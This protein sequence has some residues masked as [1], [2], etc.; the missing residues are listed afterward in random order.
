MIRTVV[1]ELARGC[2]YQKPGGT[3]LVSDGPGLFCNRLPF[4]LTVCPCCNAGIKPSRGWTWV[5][6]KILL[7]SSKEWMASEHCN[8][9]MKF[10]GALCLLLQP[11]E[12]VGLI[13]IGESFYKTPDS[14]IKEANIQGISRRISAIPRGFE[15]GKTQIW[16]AHRK[17][18]D[19]ECTKCAGGIIT[20]QNDELFCNECHGTGWIKTPGVFSAFVPQRIEYIVTGKETQEELERKEKTGITLVKLE[21]TK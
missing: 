7:G 18:Y 20:G 16:L 13:W 1:N 6:G 10:K 11:H 17:A 2:G 5:N 14:F 8:C 4:P 3:Y 19:K 21:R 12:K 9:K 15:V